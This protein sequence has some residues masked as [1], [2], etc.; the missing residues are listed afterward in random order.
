MTNYKISITKLINTAH[1]QELIPCPDGSMADA[2]IG[3]VDIPGGIVNPQSN[4]VEII[5]QIAEV[6]MNITAGLAIIVLIY[7]GIKYMTALGNDD[8]I[9]KAKTIIFWSIFGL[10]VALLASYVANF[11]LGVIG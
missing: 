8:E 11:I 3:C 7:G 2:S 4:I 1:A 5:L 10:I 9:N 6:L